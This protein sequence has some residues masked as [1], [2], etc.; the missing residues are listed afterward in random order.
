MR[1]LLVVNPKA[2][3]TSPRVADVIVSALA[4]SVDLDVTVTTHRGHA[5][6]LG[7]AARE[8]GL[9]LVLTLGG[10]GV[11]NEVVNGM[12]AAGPGPDVP[13]LAP[14]PG[15]S[16]NV[17]ARSLGLPVDPVEA[18]GMVMELLR[19]GQS[20]TIGLGRANERWFVAN[21]GLGIDAQIIEAMEQQR[22]RGKSATPAR[23]VTTSLR[24]Y[25]RGTDRRHPALSLERP[26]T[27]AS[28]VID[29]IHLAFVQNTSPW[30]Y[31]G[32]RPVN[33]CPQAAFELGLDVFAVRKMRVPTALRAVTRMLLGSAAPKPG[34]PGIV[35]WHDQ[36]DF[37]VHAHWPVPMQVDGEAAGSVQEVR[38][39][40]C[41]DALRVV[42]PS[43]T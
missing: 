14:V 35:L 36:V 32:S 1:G 5:S 23:Y 18:T 20:R 15:G 16:A 28:E 27:A 41:A 34:D 13:L 37:T 38:F 11:V 10:D 7:Q 3:T 33:P 24:T 6:R 26:G 25:F 22:A 8:E 2:T 31:L 43:R 40:A 21:A 39:T 19:E 29:G 4:S 30:T 17:F 42:A 12:L 9:D